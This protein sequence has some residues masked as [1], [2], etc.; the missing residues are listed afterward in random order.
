[1]NSKCASLNRSTSFGFAKSPTSGNLSN[2]SDRIHSKK[3]EYSRGATI[4]AR[5]WDGAN[6]S[7][8]ILGYENVSQL[9]N[10]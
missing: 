6:M 3:V 9:T 4:N 10:K 2:S 1:L 8:T 7:M 5:T